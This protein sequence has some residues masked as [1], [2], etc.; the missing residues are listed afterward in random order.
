MDVLCS[1]N[2]NVA[3]VCLAGWKG[4][5]EMGVSKLVGKREPRRHQELRKDMAVGQK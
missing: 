4:A 1:A 2:P 5:K 3:F